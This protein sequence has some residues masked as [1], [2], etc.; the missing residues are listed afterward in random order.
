MPF[1]ERFEHYYHGDPS[2]DRSS[3]LPP[4]VKPE[5]LTR[6]EQAV[7]DIHDSETFRRYLEVQARFH[8]YSF[9][10]VALILWQR[11]DSTHVAGYNTWLKLHRYV[12]RGEKAIR[13]IVPMRRKRD[14][15]D[16]DE[17]SRIFFGTGNVFDI[18]QTEGE[19]LPDIEVP[20][21]HG[22]FHEGKELFKSLRAFANRSGV[23]VR[24]ATRELGEGVMGYYDPGNK[25]IGLRPAEPLQLVKT[26]AHEVAHHELAQHFP[27]DDRTAATR[28][29]KESIAESVAYVVC[30]HFGLDTGVRS[31]P[32]I[33]LWSQ[34]KQVLKNVLTTVQKISAAMIDGIEDNAAQEDRANLGEA[35]SERPMTSP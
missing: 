20:E 32:Y 15:E 7:G 5:I 33:A 22:D 13:I 14:E 8:H 6:L 30:S 16:P 1:L 12:R 29:E 9:G 34:D 21:L 25:E 11:P 35:G 18:S 28:D 3:G 10:N 2:P 23:R 17:K 31:F 4:K 27:D 19:E 26:L 24:I